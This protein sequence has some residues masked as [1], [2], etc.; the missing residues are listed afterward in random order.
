M[1]M[2]VSRDGRSEGILLEHHEN[3]LYMDMDP[4]DK[5]AADGSIG[6]DHAWKATLA[7]LLAETPLAAS[8]WEAAQPLPHVDMDLLRAVIDG[9]REDWEDELRGDEFNLPASYRLDLHGHLHGVRTDGRS[10]RPR[11]RTSRFSTRAG[12]GTGPTGSRRTCLQ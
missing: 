9:K 12:R 10:M 8:L 7:K 4:A 5:A 3:K 1:R 6:I 2:H 11:T